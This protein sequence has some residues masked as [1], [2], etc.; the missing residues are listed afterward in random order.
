MNWN[1]KD[2]VIR[3][4][5]HSGSSLRQAS[6]SLKNDRDVVLAAL[7]DDGCA[8]QFASY[9]LQ[10]DIKMIKAAINSSNGLSLQFFAT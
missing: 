6:A 4:V 1:N 2:E 8:L 10:R 5:W 7:K 3:A 9:H